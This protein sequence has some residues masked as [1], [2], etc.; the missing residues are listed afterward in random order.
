MHIE[1]GVNRAE[2]LYKGRKG[3]MSIGKGLEKTCL[4]TGPG[5]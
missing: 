4:L 3:V 5:V 1:Q 2:R